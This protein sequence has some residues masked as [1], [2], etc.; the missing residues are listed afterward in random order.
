MTAAQAAGSLR[1]RAGEASGEQRRILVVDDDQA[2]L[3]GLTRLL[4]ASGFEV[5][6]CSDAD[7]ASVRLG[8]QVFDAVLTD[9]H[10]PRTDGLA[11]LRSLHARDEDLPVLLMTGDPTLETAVRAIDGGAVSYL[12]KGCTSHPDRSARAA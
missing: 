4:R 5:E 2:V 7:G 8:E 10:M 11:F 9:I 1:A 12:M 6:S 3:I